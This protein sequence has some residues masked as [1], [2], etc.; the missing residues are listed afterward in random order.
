[1]LRTY[2]LKGGE[3]LS[4]QR[5]GCPA[6]EHNGVRTVWK[7][8]LSP[9]D[10]AAVLLLVRGRGI[11]CEV[12]DSG[13]QRQKDHEDRSLF[14]QLARDIEYLTPECPLC[15]FFDPGTETTCGYTDWPPERVEVGKGVAAGA[16][17]VRKCPI[18]AK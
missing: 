4:L 7:A 13:V 16:E 3:S 18:L 9:E 14:R 17:S 2:L 12:F 10:H 15:Y 6:L 11:E 5:K 8:A 1:M